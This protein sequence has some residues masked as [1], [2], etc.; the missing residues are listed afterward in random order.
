MD[1][2]EVFSA[3]DWQLIFQRIGW[4]VSIATFA[5]TVTWGAIKRERDSKRRSEII[6]REQGDAHPKSRGVGGDGDSS[7]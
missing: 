1:Y 3:I 6:R 7:S 5:L 4:L 2:T